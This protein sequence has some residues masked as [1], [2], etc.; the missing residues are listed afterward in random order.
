MKASVCK[1]EGK[2][3]TSSN[4]QRNGK[5]HVIHIRKK[6]TSRVEKRNN[7][8]EHNS[9]YW[10]KQTTTRLGNEQAFY[11]VAMPWGKGI[12]K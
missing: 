1:K 6:S 7:T 12:Q 10:G 8:E 3:Q 4:I 5:T 9:K 11:K 2:V